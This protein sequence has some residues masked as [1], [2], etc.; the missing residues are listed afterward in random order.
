M[1]IADRLLCAAG[2]VFVPGGPG[3]RL[4]ILYHHRVLPEPDPLRPDTPDARLFDEWMR[5]CAAV[6]N[7][8]PV[9]EALLRMAAGTLPPRAA[10]ITFDDGY[11]DSF[12]VAMPILRRH[13]LTATFFIASGFLGHGRMFYDTVIEAVRRMPQGTL[14]LEWAGLGQRHVDDVRSRLALIDDLILVT[15]YA[16]NEDRDTFCD[17]LAGCARSPLPDT[18]MMDAEQVRAMHREG[19]T[20]GGHTVNHPI[21][22][23]MPLEQARWEIESN[24]QALG[25]L[26]DDPPALFAYPNGKPLVDY[27]IEHVEAVIGAGYQAAFTTAYGTARREHDPFQLPRLSPWERSGL[28]FAIHLLRGPACNYPFPTRKSAH[29]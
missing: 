1:T 13:G 10:C 24:R 18:L 15:K 7:V 14:D 28:R 5:H 27:R 25:S 9:E 6:F 20:I 3:A 4:S 11:R 19:M 22:N 12:E 16:S 23:E 21:L 2:N 26:L 8:L 29:A 17:R